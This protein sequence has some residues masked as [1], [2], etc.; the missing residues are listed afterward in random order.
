MP[1]RLRF[2]LVFVLFWW[3]LG[4]ALGLGLR[5][6]LGVESPDLTVRN[7]KEGSRKIPKELNNRKIPTQLCVPPE[8]CKNP[9]IA[10]SHEAAKWPDPVGRET[11][12][13]CSETCKGIS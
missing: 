1:G 7:S 12:L 13:D 5:Y 11:L 10:A 8:P 6:V 4:E 9:T 3:L 2:D